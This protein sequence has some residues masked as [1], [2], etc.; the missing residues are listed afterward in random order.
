LS[1]LFFLFYNHFAFDYS[2]VAFLQRLGF[3]VGKVAQVVA[4][5]F[6]D[7]MKLCCS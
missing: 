2:V 6:M 3:L 1:L 7:D 5:D 4:V